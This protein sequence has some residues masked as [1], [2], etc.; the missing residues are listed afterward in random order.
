M[1]KFHHWA[2]FNN[3]P[4]FKCVDNGHC[5]SAQLQSKSSTI[6]HRTL[7]AAETTWAGGGG[8]GWVCVC[9][10]W[11]GGHGYAGQLQYY[12]RGRWVRDGRE[13]GGALYL[14]SQRGSLL[15]YTGTVCLSA[16]D[17]ARRERLL[18]STAVFLQPPVPCMC[19]TCHHDVLG[20]THRWHHLWIKSAYFNALLLNV[21]FF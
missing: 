14:V 4:V 2:E 16:P 19:L 13:N 5:D 3:S 18:A 8:K 11:W 12:C 17:K 9:V 21:C 7:F 1:Q 6:H 20:V 15:F 10:W